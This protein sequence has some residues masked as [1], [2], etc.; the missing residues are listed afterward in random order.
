MNIPERSKFELR[1]GNEGDLE[2][3]RRSGPRLHSLTCF[4][5]LLSFSFQIG[6]PILCIWVGV[7]RAS[8]HCRGNATVEPGMRFCLPW[9]GLLV[10]VCFPNI[11][12]HCFQAHSLAI[13]AFW[14]MDG[15]RCN[16]RKDKWRSCSRLGSEASWSYET[17]NLASLLVF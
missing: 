7:L 14:V 13:S 3:H 16:G 15:E 9:R 11:N 2:R 1:C 8:R 12:V 6:R 17:Q 10:V 5:W 4:A